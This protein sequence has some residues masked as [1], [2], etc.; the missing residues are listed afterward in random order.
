VRE[1]VERLERRWPELAEVEFAVQ[2]VPTA[3]DLDDEVGGDAG[4]ADSGAG[5]GVGSPGA[6]EELLARALGD[7]GF[8]D[9]PVEVPLARTV[10]ARDGDPVRIVVF[11]R[12]VEIRARGRDERAALVHDVV[13]EQVADLLGKDPEDVDPRYGE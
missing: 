7:W 1:S 10:S 3:E 8:G 12:P 2:E 11:R 9:E 6:D 13:V 5:A 4:G